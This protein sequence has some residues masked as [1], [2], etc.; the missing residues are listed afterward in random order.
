M[1]IITQ[2]YIYYLDNCLDKSGTPAL[3]NYFIQ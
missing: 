3:Y 1:I 2:F